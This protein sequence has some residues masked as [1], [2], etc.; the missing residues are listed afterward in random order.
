MD[1][2]LSDVSCNLYL[3]SFSS[4]FGFHQG[5]VYVLKTGEAPRKK[6]ASDSRVPSVNCRCPFLAWFHPLRFFLV[7]IH[8]ENM[9]RTTQV[10]KKLHVSSQFRALKWREKKMEDTPPPTMDIH[11]LWSLPYPNQIFPQSSVMN[12]S[13]L[14]LAP[15]CFCTSLYI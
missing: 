2:N 5:E 4:R 7:E 11:G 10:A 14:L 6:N 9:T 3:L 15:N 12:I 13:N 8:P 1:S